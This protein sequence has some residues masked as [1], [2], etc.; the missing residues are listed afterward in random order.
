MSN[1]DLVIVWLIL[2]AFLFIGMT[3]DYIIY[4][5]KLGIPFKVAVKLFINQ[6]KFW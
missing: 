6:F 5:V 2:C 3:L 4:H 1:I